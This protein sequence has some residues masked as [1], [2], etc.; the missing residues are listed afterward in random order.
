MER[1]ALGGLGQK[2]LLRREAERAGVA[3]VRLALD[4]RAA[5]RVNSTSLRRLTLRAERT[6]GAAGA[7]AQGRMR[8]A[9]VEGR[10]EGGRTHEYTSVRA[11]MDARTDAHARTRACTRVLPGASTCSLPFAAVAPAPPAA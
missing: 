9:C 11:R 4:A 10:H 7:R 2:Q 1:L 6:G 8:A 3:L 5:A